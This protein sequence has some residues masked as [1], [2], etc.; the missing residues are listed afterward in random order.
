MAFERELTVAISAVTKASALC[1][2]VQNTLCDDETVAKEDRSPVTIADFGSQALVIGDIRRSFPEDAV[3]GE[4]DAAILRENAELEEKVHH[5][6]SEQ[7]EEIDAETMLNNIDFGAA[8]TDFSKRYWTLDPIDGTKG[9][10][11]GDQYAIA[12]ALV[13][14][15][16][17]VLGVLGCPN[18]PLEDDNPDA[19]QGCILYA[20]KDEGAFQK[21]LASEETKQIT[22][23]PISEVKNAWFCESVEK[24]HSKH[25]VHKR[26]GE[27][28]GITRS[29]Y[30]IDSQCKY[31]VIARGGVPIY[32][33]LARGKE[34]KEKIWDH[35]AG[36]FIVQEAGGQV[37]DF[38]NNELDFSLGRTL[39]K[40]TGI[41]AT[42]GLLHNNVLS[43]IKK[44]LAD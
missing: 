16:Q 42:N 27:L 34:Y 2:K 4:E 7:N 6:V 44:A 32:L 12:L 38:S 22:V 10:L 3:V 21:A 5:L 37:T 19:G 18:L 23:N 31:A 13:E 25:D 9:F 30:R 14:N 28:L 43:A 17:V 15:G 35:A 20:V 39:D 36:A 33:R 11:R 26:I 8:D 40:N 24:G 29:P 41:L 1:E